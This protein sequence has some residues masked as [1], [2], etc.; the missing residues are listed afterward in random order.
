MVEHRTPN[1]TINL[2]HKGE[3][4]AKC[5]SMLVTYAEPLSTTST[6]SAGTVARPSEISLRTHFRRSFESSSVGRIRRGPG[7]IAI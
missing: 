2:R 5:H 3:K 4:Y 1:R 6:A 7:K